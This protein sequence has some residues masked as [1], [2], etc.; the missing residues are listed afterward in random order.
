M[1]LPVGKTDGRERQREGASQKPA[2]NR[3]RQLL[4]S[5]LGN[6]QIP[7]FGPRRALLKPS[8]WP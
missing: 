8:A 7:G 6:V 2:N 5:D 3:A 1:S 4:R